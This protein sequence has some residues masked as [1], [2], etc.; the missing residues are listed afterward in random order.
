M[1]QKD[2]AESTG[3]ALAARDEFLKQEPESAKAIREFPTLVVQDIGIETE[4]RVEIKSGIS[5]SD[6][7][8]IEGLS[9]IG[10]GTKLF[11]VEK[12]D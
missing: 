6:T 2:V 4:N 5:A 3:I 1:L 10:D 7:V 8:V 9:L 12:E 11:T